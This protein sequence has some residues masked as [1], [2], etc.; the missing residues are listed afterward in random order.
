MSI[1]LFHDPLFTLSIIY[2][3]LFVSGHALYSEYIAGF[4][5]AMLSIESQEDKAR[6]HHGVTGKYSKMY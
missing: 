6:Y 5:N 1:S 2:V 4:K 3:Y